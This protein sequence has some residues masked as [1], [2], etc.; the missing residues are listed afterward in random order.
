MGVCSFIFHPSDKERQPRLPGGVDDGILPVTRIVLLPHHTPS[1]PCQPCY[2]VCMYIDVHISRVLPGCL[3]G[4]QRGGSLGAVF[5][6]L[7]QTCLVVHN[8]VDQVKQRWPRL[9][10]GTY[11]LLKPHDKIFWVVADNG[12]PKARDGPTSPHSKRAC[13]RIGGKVKVTRE[14]AVC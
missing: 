4:A 1:Q 14:R 6:D 5:R 13:P 9:V 7:E 11:S 8:T 3:R 10:A 2:C 12:V